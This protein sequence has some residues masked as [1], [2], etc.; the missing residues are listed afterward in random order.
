MILGWTY[1][2]R[3]LIISLP[4]Q[5]YTAWAHDLDQLLLKGTS[6]HNDLNSIIGRLNHVTYVIPTARHFLSRIR[7]F[8]SSLQ[9]RRLVTIPHLVK[10]DIKL[11]LDFLH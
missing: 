5:K 3:S 2:T 4:N 8:K 1:N 7:H 10:Q 9:F 6:S 11:W